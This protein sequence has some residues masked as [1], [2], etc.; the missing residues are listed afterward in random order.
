[1]KYI[2]K[3]NWEKVEKLLWESDSLI[4]VTLTNLGEKHKPIF[5]IHKLT[6]SDKKI[7]DL[8]LFDINRF[9]KLVRESRYEFWKKVM[10][11][12]WGDFDESVEYYLND[13][14]SRFQ[15]YGKWVIGELLGT[16]SVKISRLV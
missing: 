15:D 4:A 16:Q 10:W 13:F 12:D 5:K 7:E 1:M 6:P 8:G 2:D 14:Y 3:I 9:E 11:D